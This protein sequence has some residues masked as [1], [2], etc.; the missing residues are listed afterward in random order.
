M[1]FDLTGYTL[2]ELNALRTEEEAQRVYFSGFAATAKGQQRKR[3]L[4]DAAKCA[5]LIVQI[6]AEVKG[7]S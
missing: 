7:R 6:D 5:D 2:E 3:D 1:S 4:A